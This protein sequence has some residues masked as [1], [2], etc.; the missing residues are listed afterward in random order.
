MK[1]IAYLLFA[2]AVLLASCSR[3]YDDPVAPVQEE[4]PVF[5][6]TVLA[7]EDATKTAVADDGAGGYAISWQSGDK[8][9]VFE[10]S[11]GS[12]QAKATSKPLAS[13]V[14]TANFEFTLAGELS[15]PFEYTFVYPSAAL[16]QVDG[17]YTISIPSS[18]LFP[19]NSFDPA[20][21]VLVSEHLSQNTRPTTVE[22]RFARLGGTGKMT[23]NAP[24]TSEKVLWISLESPEDLL[25]GSYLLSPASGDL[26]DTP[27]TGEKVLRLYPNADLA[28]TGTLDI[29]FRCVAVTLTQELTVTVQTDT[30]KYIKRINLASAG[31]SIVF[32][33]GKLTTFG[34]NMASIEGTATNVDVFTTTNTNNTTTYTT[35]SK[36]SKDMPSGASYWGYTCRQ[37]GGIQMKSDKHGSPSQHTGIV[38]TATGGYVKSV[39]IIAATGGTEGH[40]FD[41]YGKD[42]NYTS[43][44]DLWATGT[45]AY[46]KG[47]K[48]GSVYQSQEA[49]KVGTIDFGGNYTGVGIRSFDGASQATKIFI[50]WGE[51]PMA[52]ATV[53]TGAASDLDH[54]SATVSG[55]YS[56]ATG[57]IYEAGFYWDT[58]QDALEGLEHP[59]NQVVA[60]DSSSPFS[61]MLTSLEENTKYYY[62]AYV[63]E[64]DGSLGAYVE[65]Y[66]DIQSFT[67]TTKGVYVPGGW[68]ELPSTTVYPSTTTSPLTD[69]YPMTHKALMGSPATLQRNYTMLYDPA[70]YAS[71][72]VAYPLC[73][74]HM[75]AGRDEFWGFDPDVPQSKQT[76]IHKGAYGVKWPT[77][78]YANNYFARGHQLPN[79]DRNGDTASAMLEQ[80]YYSTN[81]TPQLQYGFNGDIWKNLEE[82]VRSCV[83]G[84]DTVYVVTGAAFKKVGESKDITT[85]VSVRD[86]KT[87]PVPNYYWKVLLKVKW[88]GTGKD[89][90]VNSALAVGFW[91]DHWGTYSTAS[92]AFI[93]YAV[94]V[95]Q[96]ETWTGFDFF[97]NLSES[98][99]SSAEANTSWDDFKDF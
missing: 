83:S 37:F 91:L 98:L 45:D 52:T 76:D 47:V 68:L 4:K 66:G 60:I 20:A 46:K 32:Q 16:G 5:H 11:N 3:E 85:I 96:I 77:A 71:Y 8:L 23:I 31:A 48:Q 89:K 81:L 64:Y 86:G 93:P 25:A 14:T 1:R 26:D 29:W 58:T 17:H 15:A 50:V 33:N 87:L 69:L 34:V 24:S 59:D 99:Q 7:G 19:S 49:V 12:V 35:W 30:K 43:A 61:A 40:R 22:A 36:A 42:G 28:Y 74:T 41:I 80:T 79:A 97:K 67:T 57:V 63:L 38:S 84:S 90:A 44:D 82:G 13:A 53:I 9:G 55:S 70:M 73:T 62:K 65:H 39:T 51:E 10:V 54:S 92:D 21:D 72:W 56:G 2:G 75:G 6:M 94:S 78:N 88:T 27:F 95:N 18:Q